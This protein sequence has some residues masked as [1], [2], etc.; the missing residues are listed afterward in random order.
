VT[1]HLMGLPI[2]ERVL[3]Y[4]PAAGVLITAGTFAVRTR[5]GDLRRRLRQRP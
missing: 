2:E 3:Q 5:L 1:A 4:A